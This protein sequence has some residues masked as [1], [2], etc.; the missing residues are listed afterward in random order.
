MSSNYH[1]I[2]YIHE[3]PDALS[4]TLVDN[5]APVQK[6]VASAQEKH[7]QKIVVVSVGSS[8]TAGLMAAPVFRKHCP[9][10]TYILPATELGPLIPELVDEHSLVVAVS[11]SG[12]RGW[13]VDALKESIQ[14]GA[15]GVAVTGLADNLLA[16]NAQTI[17]LT[18]EG[19]EITFAKTKS[20]TT[21]SGLLMQLALALA[22]PQDQVAANRL[23]LLY[24]TPTLL[25]EVLAAVEPQIQALMPEIRAHKM[26]MAGGTVSNYGAALEFGIKLQEAA[27]VPVM[28]ND[29]GNL[30]HG[31]WGPVN[32]DWLIMLLVTSYD[33]E[34]SKKTL[35]LAGALK[36]HRLV[37]ADSGLELEDLC[38]YKIILPKPVDLLI[39]GLTYLIP[40]Q[41]LT[42]YWSLANGLNPDAPAEMRVMLDAMLPPGREEPELR[43][44]S[45]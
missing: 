21:C 2:E 27:N 44:P 32:A 29:T 12:E 14:R 45:N 28:G 26:V 5:E 30:L 33:L 37:I 19:P 40:L 6:I 35:Q 25:R 7:I 9:L 42:Y 36:G 39:S 22:K 3:I 17:L 11:R 24:S 31:P 18:G 13:V 8:Y 34:L 38:E 20:V 1:M 16:Q 23:Q 4:K 10:P 41:L 15:M 43:S